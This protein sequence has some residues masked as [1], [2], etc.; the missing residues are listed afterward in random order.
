LHVYDKSS[1]DI[2]D[3]ALEHHS[4]FN[5]NKVQAR[6]IMQ[7][8]ADALSKWEQVAEK[9]SV[10]GVDDIRNRFYEQKG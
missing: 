8:V 6:E 7:E 4:H 5:L 10:R 2:I 1:P 3:T 9:N